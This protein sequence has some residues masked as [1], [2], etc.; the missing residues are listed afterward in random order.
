MIIIIFAL[1]L[2]KIS[3]LKDLP[4]QVLSIP[5]YA[6]SFPSAIPLQV[7]IGST[8]VTLLSNM[9]SKLLSKYGSQISVTKDSTNANAIA[10]DQN[11][12]F[13]KKTSVQFLMGG[14]FFNGQITAGANT[15]Y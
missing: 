6:G 10:F 12:L 2:M 9:E 11:T 7:P 13:P 15:V 5:T 4:E 8:D 3:F 14:I 1:L